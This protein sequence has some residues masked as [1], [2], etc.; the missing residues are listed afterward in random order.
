[1]LPVN[2][3]L[4]E[5]KPNAGGVSALSMQKK[6]V[7]QDVKTR[8]RRMLSSCKQ[9][10]HLFKINRLTGHLLN[11]NGFKTTQSAMPKYAVLQ[12]ILYFNS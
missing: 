7:R 9:H 3:P 6:N 2:Y 1:L 11:Y 10:K 12:T 4:Y 8:S 5:L